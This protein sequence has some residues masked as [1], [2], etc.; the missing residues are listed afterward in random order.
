MC[1]EDEE[2]KVGGILWSDALLIALL[3]PYTSIIYVS[4]HTFQA[5]INKAAP[6][7]LADRH[8]NFKTDILQLSSLRNEDRWKT[9]NKARCTSCDS[10]RARFKLNSSMYCYRRGEQYQTLVNIYYKKGRL[11]KWEACQCLASPSWESMFVRDSHKYVSR[12]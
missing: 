11:R 4:Q 1:H 10:I 5:P 9:K 8:W 2:T 6:F 12:C 3:S 7:H